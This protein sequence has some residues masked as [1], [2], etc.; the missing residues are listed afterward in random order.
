M[1]TKNPYLYEALHRAHYQEL[2]QQAALDRL[3]QAQQQ[4]TVLQWAARRLLQ[5]GSALQHYSERQ[6]SRT[7]AVHLLDGRSGETLNLSR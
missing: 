4:H 5:L 7:H 3:V 6:L 1:E 2:L